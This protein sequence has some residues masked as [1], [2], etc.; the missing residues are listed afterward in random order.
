MSNHRYPSDL[1]VTPQDFAE[2][3]WK[4]VLEQAPRKGY[5]VMQQPLFDA[6]RKA[7]EEDR[8][9]Q[10][11]VFWLLANACSMRL[12]PKS[13]NEPFKPAVW[14]MGGKRSAIPDDFSDSDIAFFAQIVDMV[15]DHW[16]KA[17]LADL[18]WLKQ[19]PRND[20]GFAL[21]AIDAY[22]SI[23]LDKMTWVYGGRE[24]WARA[25][26]LTRM[27]KKGA[28][29]R[30]QEMET[31]ILKA[32]S[33]TTKED[34]PLGLA[35]LLKTQSLGRSHAATVAQK[36]ETLAH[37]FSNGGDY[38]VCS[39]FSAS[40]DWYEMS[41]DKAKAAEMTVAEAE[42]WVSVAKCHKSYGVAANCYEKA[43][44]IYRS[45]P[46]PERA[47]H[48]VDER[49]A[50]LHKCLSE[51]G[52]NSLDE[53]RRVKTSA[54][55]IREWEDCASKSVM[56]KPVHEAMYSF[57]N[58]H[59]GAKVD[60]IRTSAKEC[61]EQSISRNICDST[62]RS[63]DGR[64]IA[65]RP[66]AGF[67]ENESSENSALWAKMVEDY[68]I[69][70]DLVVRGY[71]L[72]AHEILLQEHRLQEKDFIGLAQQSP[73]VPI[74][75]AHLFGKA[76]YA[77]YDRDFIVA[78]HLLSPQIEHMVRFHLNNAGVKTTNSDNNGIENENGLSTLMD[79][80][81]VE[82]IFGPDL[83]FEIKALFCDAFG[84]NLRNE[85][86]HGLLADN[87]F[88]LPCIYAWWLGLRLVVN[89][90]WNAARMAQQSNDQ[91]NAHD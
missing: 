49:I 73:I 65:K 88:Q 55:D 17:R 54:I 46:R 79:K 87:E 48:K 51:A 9:A 20:V 63:R 28:G 59:E 13:H 25:L 15:D 89:T 33:T 56:G 47:K 60:Q 71:I 31:E 35:E 64:V 43:I 84:P 45:I 2:S 80:P 5:S 70:V 90:F 82:K 37:E 74:G 40:V 91:E 22:R 75:R 81:E 67:S 42:S 76:L 26:V 21:A 34:D 72:P 11:K 24:C 23:P 78:I 38:R 36:L 66:A 85:L 41:G 69:F 62:Y 57:V 10:G 1:V 30:L 16:L 3:G 83:A 86:A 7:I 50:E 6:E 19:K 52:K 14:I 12:V 8:Q 77:G 53:L 18:V 58:I 4:E 39:F 68:Q 44:Q 29:E 32:F 61:L 27:L